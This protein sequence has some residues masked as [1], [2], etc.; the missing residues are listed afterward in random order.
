MLNQAMTEKQ[1]QSVSNI[2]I[3]NSVAVSMRNLLLGKVEP[4]LISTFMHS[5]L[6]IANISKFLK[7]HI[8]MCQ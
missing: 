7:Q 5:Q 6:N 4:F 1:N 2:W 3:V 8:K